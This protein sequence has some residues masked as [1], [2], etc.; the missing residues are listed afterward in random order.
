MDQP[1]KVVNPA[2]G[3][4]NRENAYFPVLV[5]ACEFGST[6]QVRSFRPALACSFSILRMKLVVPIYHFTRTLRFD[7][8]YICNICVCVCVCIC[9]CTS[10]QLQHCVHGNSGTKAVGGNGTYNSVHRSRRHAHTRYMISHLVQISYW[11]ITRIMRKHTGTFCHWY[12]II[13]QIVCTE[14]RRFVGEHLT[15]YRLLTARKLVNSTSA[16]SPVA[17]RHRPSN[18]SRCRY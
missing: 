9:K 12:C 11:C 5:C 1:G 16:W 2:R 10:G 14:Q 15:E 7:T 13:L 17:P 4:L 6:R 18:R 8:L 3:Q